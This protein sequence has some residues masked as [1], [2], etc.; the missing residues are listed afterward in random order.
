MPKYLSVFSP[1]A[2]KYKTEKTPY[3]NTFHT[4]VFTGFL[5]KYFLKHCWKCVEVEAAS[6]RCS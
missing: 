2:G 6:R 5:G 4:V 1:N 3:L